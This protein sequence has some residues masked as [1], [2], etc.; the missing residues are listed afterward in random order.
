MP[1]VDTSL[2]ALAGGMK[3]SAEDAE[4]LAKALLP[5]ARARVYPASFISGGGKV[6][7]AG[8]CGERGRLV[9]EMAKA[10]APGAHSA[11]RLGAYS[12]AEAA[13]SFDELRALQG[14][15]EF[16]VP[17]ALG[18]ATSAGLGDRLGSATVGHARATM[19]TGVAPVFAQQSIREM[20]RTHRSPQDVMAD[21]AWGVLASGWREAW[22]ADADHLKSTG[23][24][25][26][27]AAAGFVL[28]TIDPGE[29]VDDEADGRSGSDLDA[30]LD[31]LPWGALETAPADFRERHVKSPDDEIRFVRAAA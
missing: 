25:D 31:A 27:C 26:R 14:E 19:G 8:R 13:W 20:T 1:E 17:R 6:L 5:V 9:I 23:N 12:I 4:A 24:V 22:G 15:L 7:A 16:L 28:I 11:K 30:A 29:H 18:G 10:E 2:D 21:A 3:I